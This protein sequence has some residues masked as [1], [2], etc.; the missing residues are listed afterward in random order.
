VLRLGFFPQ[1]KGA[2]LVLLA[3]EPGDIEYLSSQLTRFAASS[4]AALAIHNFATTSQQHPA[5]LFASRSTHNNGVGFYWECSPSE[6]PTIQGKLAALASS[7]GHQYFPL[8]S[9]SVQL[10]LSAGEYGPSWWQAHG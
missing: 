8:L 2:D 9:S 10:V 7:T 6:L 5:Q 4:E 3:G 1:F